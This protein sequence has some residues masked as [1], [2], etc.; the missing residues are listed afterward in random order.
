MVDAHL[1]LEAVGGELTGG[2]H[3]QAGVVDQQ[4]QSA[5]GALGGN[6]VAHRGQAGQVQVHDPECGVRDVVAD[7][8]RRGLA[9]VD[10]TDGHHHLGTGAGERERGLE[11]ETGVRSGHHCALAEL[12][13]YRKALPGPHDRSCIGM[14]T[15]RTINMIAAATGTARIAPVTP[16][17]AAPIRIA[18]TTAPVEMSTVRR[19]TLG[20]SQ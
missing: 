1:T 8:L 9:A 20:Y 16:S 4:V 6:E 11:P 12:I 17:S 10:V 15:S 19:I 13:R 2:H 7:P 18:I 14:I 3:H 5:L